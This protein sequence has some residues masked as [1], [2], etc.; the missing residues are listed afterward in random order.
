MVGSEL[1]AYS[2]EGEMI[3]KWVRA[4]FAAGR[5][6]CIVNDEGDPRI[7]EVGVARDVPPRGALV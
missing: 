2:E 6:L 3:L 1:Q 4:Q 7:V 5:F